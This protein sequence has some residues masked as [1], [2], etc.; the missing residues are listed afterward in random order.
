[1]VQVTCTTG[2]H[3]GHEAA[4]AVHET[5]LFRANLRG[6]QFS[7]VVRVAAVC[8]FCYPGMHGGG[9]G[10]GARRHTSRVAIHLRSSPGRGAYP[11]YRAPPISS[12]VRPLS[13]PS[14]FPY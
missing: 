7:L 11:T 6:L 3:E 8:V 2:Q 14:Q 13:T 9:G 1:M 10:S 5:V 12:G 4:A